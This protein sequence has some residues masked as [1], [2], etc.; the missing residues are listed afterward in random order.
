MDHI[1]HGLFVRAI[2]SALSVVAND[3]QYQLLSDGLHAFQ[4]PEHWQW[5]GVGGRR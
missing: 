2:P 4:L 1:G 5:L 3:G